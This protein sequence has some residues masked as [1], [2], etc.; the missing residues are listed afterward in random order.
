MRS[1]RVIANSR[2]QRVFRALAGPIAG[3]SVAALSAA[4]V[5]FVHAQGWTLYYGDADAHL[6][7]ARGMLDSQTPGYDQIGTVWLPLLHALTLPLVRYDAL[8]RDGLAGAIPVAICFVAAGCFFFAAVLRLFGR[9]SAAAA[10]L[11]VFALNP[12]MLYLQSIPMTEGVFFGALMALLYFSVRFRQTQGWGAAI[13]A[14]V[15]A[16]AASL[17]RYEGWFLIPVAAVYFLW[18]AKRRQ[19]LVAILFCAIAALGPL[20]WFG[21][22]WWL[23]GD[24]LD[25]YRG[26]YSARAIQ[27]RAT[28]PGL[29]DWR[30]AW[31]Y[32]CAAAELCAGPLLTVA[33]LAGIAAGMLQRSFWPMLLLAVP[34]LA[35]IASVHSGGVPIF[36]PTLWPHSYYNAR[37]GTSAIPLF[38]LGV[39]ALVS[40]AP[41]RRQTAAAVAVVVLSASWWAIRWHPNQWV[42]WEESRVNSEGRRAWTREAAAYLEPLY[43]RGTG[44]VTSS[45]P[46]TGILRE[47]GI[48]LGEALYVNNG[49]LWD[50]LVDRPDLY[51]NQEWIIAQGGDGA[52]TAVN[53]AGRYGMMYRLEKRIV[54]KDQPVIEIYRR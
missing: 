18:A 33:G 2:T 49:L 35:Y 34:P 29:H 32:Y 51:L 39:A 12:N 15:S 16:C 38:A 47:A 14:G 48:P 46:L 19:A 5:W 44:I 23:S 25:F 1:R 21:N 9:V 10:A 28:Y 54:V 52:Q 3:L 7:I 17:T 36:L 6:M 42:A 50:A 20:Y 22:N 40:A 4:A 27:G 37:Y 31:I 8:W 43:V 53:R 13:G 11:A 30:N 24:W 41:L 45:Y 26:P